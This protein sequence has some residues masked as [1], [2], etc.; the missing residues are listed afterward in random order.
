MVPVA[1]TGIQCYVAEVF[2]LNKQTV[3]SSHYNNMDR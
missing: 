1:V 3:V 2:D